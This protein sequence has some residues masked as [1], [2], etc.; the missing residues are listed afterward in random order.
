[1]SEELAQ[2]ASRLEQLRLRSASRDPE[3][4]GDFLVSV[5]L[6]VVEHEHGPSTWRQFRRRFLDR[7]G[8]ERPIVIRLDR[9]AVFVHFRFNRGEPSILSQC[10]ERPID[11]DSVRPGAEL[12]IASV[13]GQ[14]AED[15]NP[16]F[17]R[18]VRREVHVAADQSAYDQVDVRRVPSPEGSERALIARDRATND[19]RFVIHV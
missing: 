8:D 19:L 5:S 17:L 7:L 10:V 6:D 18:N 4:S 1:M 12:G 16:H 3:F 11:R 2:L 13:G 15:L 9:R 14:R